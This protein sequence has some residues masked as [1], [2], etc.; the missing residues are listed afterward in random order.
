M[1]SIQ[2]FEAILFVCVGFSHLLSPSDWRKIF[3]RMLNIGAGAAVIEGMIYV[4]SGAFIVCQH[5]VW[6]G[7]PIVL[8]D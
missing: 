5:P 3:Q 2:A 7:L 8:P 1:K 4:W 6:S